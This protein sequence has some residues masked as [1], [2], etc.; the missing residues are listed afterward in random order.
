[1]KRYL[2]SFI[3]I[4]FFFLTNAQVVTTTCGNDTIILEVENYNNGIIEWEE[5][6]DSTLWLTIE[7]ETGESYKFFPS[8]TKYY[9]ASVITAECDPLYSAITLVQLAPK[10]YAGSDREFGGNTAKLMGSYETGSVGTWSIIEGEN[11]S[12]T[13]PN[14]P[15][16]E[17]TGEYDEPYQLIWTVTNGCGQSTDTVSIVLEEIKAKD[18]FIVVDNTDIIAGD[19]AER[20]SGIYRIQFSDAS[21]MP[22][23]TMM[24]IGMREDISFIVKILSYTKENDFYVISTAVGGIEDIIQSGPVNV[25]DGVNESMVND[26]KSKFSEFPTRKT[27]KEYAKNKNQ[28]VIYSSDFS[29]QY[30]NRMSISRKKSS[31]K[32]L[33]LSIPD[34]ELFASEDGLISASIENTYVRFEPNFVCDFKIGFF[35]IKKIKIGLENG[36]FE[37]NYKLSISATAAK[38]LSKE[39]ELLEL[40]NNTVFMVGPVPVLIASSFTIKAAAS[41][42][43]AATLTVSEEKNYQKNFTALLKGDKLKNVE[44]ISFSTS[45]TTTESSYS[46]EGRLD[47]EF[48][49]GPEISVELYKVIGPYF[50]LPLTFAAGICMNQNLNWSA[51]ASL[52]IEGNLGV[53]AHLGSLSLFDIQHTLFKAELMRPLVLPYKLALRSGNSQKGFQETL[54]GKPITLKVTSNYGFGVPLVPVRFWL[55]EGD[56]SIYDDVKFTDKDGMVTVDDWTI[57]TNSTSQLEISVLN[58]DDEDIEKN[59]PLTAY[60]YT[61][62]DCSNTDLAISF[63]KNENAVI[64]LAKGGKA[65]Y[66]YSTDG[67]NFSASVPEFDNLIEGNFKVYVKDDNLCNANKA[68][69]IKIQDPCTVSPLFID[70]YSEANTFQFTGIGGNSPYQFSIDNTTSFTDNSLYSNLEEGTHTVYIKDAKDCMD[71]D[72][73]AIEHFDANAIN[74]L[75]PKNN[76]QYYTASDI[77]FQWQTGLYA[78]NQIYDLYLEKEGEAYTAIAQNLTLEEYTHTATLDFSSLYNWKVVVKD[79]NGVEK[80]FRKFSFTTMSDPSILAQVPTLLQPQNEALINDFTTLKWEKQNG[81]FKYDVYIDGNLVAY[82]LTCDSVLV[83]NLT[84]SMTY[85]WKVVIKNILTSE[86]IESPE[87]NFEVKS[88]LPNVNTN[89]VMDRYDVWAICG[90]TITSEGLAPVT[91]RGICYGQYENPTIDSSHMELGAGLGF[92]EDTISGLKQETDYYVRAYAINNHGISYGN[93]ETFTTTPPLPRDFDGNIYSTVKIGNQEWFAEN[94]KTTKYNDGTDVTTWWYNNDISNKEIYGGLYNFYDVVMTE[95]GGKNVCPIGWRIPSQ[96]DFE[97]LLAFIGD[98]SSIK[99]REMGTQYWLDGGYGFGTDDYGFSARGTGLYSEGKYW[100]V[101]QRTILMTSDKLTNPS[102][103]D[104]PTGFVINYNGINSYFSD[105]GKDERWSIRCIKD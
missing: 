29:D 76:A 19:S 69:S 64:P 67:F 104:Y 15:Y 21:I 98:S 22:S 85:N 91:S 40:S 50:E 102:M 5:S 66:S 97:E 20:A 79:A 3:V 80:D 55:D 31:S 7:G 52:G 25:G 14:D 41:L 36:E 61:V 56:G 33:K 37:Y 49:I 26:G 103:G 82:A 105:R 93:Q 100:N 70:V 96:A 13:N 4:C 81:D 43:A 47:A 27:L 28:V 58:C 16:S 42:S 48:T 84:P 90:G 57:G 10:A 74:A 18:N 59:S 6:L 83:N 65:P 95:N 12:I 24:L 9:R 71:S 89:V 46:L 72:A 75:K 23:D 63:T 78:E 87:W 77:N 11:G 35:T 54:L 17:F 45:K 1:M 44:F 62:F 53:R 2:L 92:F 94:L 68:V 34:Q 73:I 38:E 51:E 8:E 99:L 32:G 30:G 101:G 88:L 60:A 39:V 86:T